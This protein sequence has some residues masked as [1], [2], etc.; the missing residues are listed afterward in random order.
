MSPISLVRLW[1][2]QWL[3]MVVTWLCLRYTAWHYLYR[4]YREQ[5][6]DMVVH[7]VYSIM[8]RVLYTVFV[9]KRA[10]VVYIPV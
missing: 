2:K 10:V 6:V 1:R 8:Y 5:F 7:T 3:Y 9:V 4:L